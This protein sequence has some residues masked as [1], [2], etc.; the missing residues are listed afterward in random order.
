MAL[1][2][3]VGVAFI[4][5][6]VDGL[7]G[8]SDARPQQAIR[9]RHVVTGMKHAV[10]VEKADGGIIAASGVVRLSARQNAFFA[11]PVVGLLKIHARANA[12]VPGGRTTEAPAVGLTADGRV[13]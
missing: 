5:R 3:G 10:G 4:P 12:V 13:S 1:A 9:P 7:A 8:V 11:R 2:T 6:L